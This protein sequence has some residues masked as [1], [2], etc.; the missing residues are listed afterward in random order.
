VFVLEDSA[1]TDATPFVISATGA[2]TTYSDI[3]AM[4]TARFV[5]HGV[6]VQ[7]TAST[8]PSSPSKGD[9]IFQTDT[10]TYFGWNGT[11]WASIGGGGGSSY[12]PSMPS[13]P[14]DGGLWVDS[15]GSTN[16]VNAND[17]YTKAQMDLLLADAGFSPFFLGGL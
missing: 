14:T 15:D 4:D 7:C 6:V 13:S 17:Y 9:I 5:G 1:S 10:N 12:Q 2:L 8:R 3:T 11:A 16:V